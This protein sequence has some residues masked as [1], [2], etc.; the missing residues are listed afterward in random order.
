[1]TFSPLVYASWFLLL[2]ITQLTKQATAS[3]IGAE[4]FARQVLAE[5]KESCAPAQLSQCSANTRCGASGG[6]NGDQGTCLNIGG[7]STSLCTDGC[8]YSIGEFTVVQVV[9]GS[10][11]INSLGGP[12]L[13]LGFLHFFTAGV[14]EGTSLNYRFLPIIWPANAPIVGCTFNFN[15]DACLCERRYCD[16]SQST[17][18]D[19]IDCSGL[20]GGSA[21]DMCNPPSLTTELPL[22]ELLFW[23]P[24]Q[25]C[26]EVGGGGGDGDGTPGANTGDGST[27]AASRGAAASVFMT[28]AA[29]ALVGL[30]AV[31]Y[32]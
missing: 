7:Q 19:F 22:M 31:T 14:A 3:C 5:R 8:L 26:D 18:G 6:L 17:T 32:F 28:A 24:I 23:L 13:S 9:S 12:G 4:G 29:A 27:S 15:G 16:A 2:I 20:P 30:L 1:M 11:F 25:F 10:S 21:I